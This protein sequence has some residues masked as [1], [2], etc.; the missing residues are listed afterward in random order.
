MEKGS[1]QIHSENILPIIKKWLY[2][3]KDIY[4]RE[5]VSNACDAIQ[6][7]KILRDQGLVEVKDEDF[8]IDIQINKEAHTLTFTDNGIGMDAEEVKKY[9]AQI[10]FSGAE[11]FLS[12]YQSNNENDQIIGHF[13]LGF[14]SAY[15][16]ADKVEI[17]TLSYKPDSEPVL[18]TCDGSSDYELDRGTR[19]TRGTEITLFIG[20]EHDECLDPELI[21]K[22]LT[23]YCS[24]LPY[25]IYL[26]GKRI[27]EYE[28]L[29]IKPAS[30][31]TKEDYLKFYHELFPLEE[32]P[33]FWVHLNVDYPFRLKGILYFPKIRRDF[34]MN[35]SSVS[36]YCNRVFVS[37]TCKDLIPNYLT[38]LKGVIDSPD[39]PL[40]VSRS[41]LQMD[42]TVRQ[43]ANHISKKVSDSLASLYKTDRERFIQAW[44][45]SSL[46]VKLGILEDEKFYER[47][48]EFLIWKNTDK[49][50]TTIADYLDRNQEK[51]KNKIFYTID[52]KHAAHVLDI[53]RKQGIEIL[54]ANTPLDPYLINFLETKLSPVSFQ[55][56][57]AE[58]HDNIVD[59]SREKT[60]LDAE[61]KTEAV[62]LEDFVRS[63]LNDETVDVQA[64]SLASDALPGFILIDEKQRRMREY[65]MRLDPEERNLQ[66]DLFNKKTFVINTN[67]SLVESIEKLDRK[68][69]ELAKELI[70]EVYEL[71]LLSQREMDPHALH[72]FINR[73]N[74]VL[75]ALTKE[76]L[77]NL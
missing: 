8:R 46:I 42:R 30:E 62:K 75:E 3:D 37:D 38:V 29:W 18:W 55:R 7:V 25:P 23:H 32:D 10:A 45:D 70:Q 35:K 56:I 40:N 2:S 21:G 64:K 48:K 27:N 77:K 39:I 36:L 11:E 44:Q 19:E 71:A 76:A 74:R 66:M 51:A 41:Y 72:E 73:S 5:L 61:G 54:C 69:P 16:V 14:Y 58:V 22:I 12:N 60:V 50:W 13:G 26:D 52:E 43:L 57:D 20:K 49:E 6:K 47:A 28:P 17:N 63:K 9:I 1:L 59:K 65:M 24:F 53:Y 4:V 15:M 68:N 34:D 31:C 67:N 33:L